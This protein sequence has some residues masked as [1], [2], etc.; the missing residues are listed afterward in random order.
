MNSSLRLIPASVAAVFSVLLATDLFAKP[1][2]ASFAELVQQSPVI[3][4]GR[5][6]TEGSS[7]P[8]PGSG[9][10]PFKALQVL[11]GDTSL[12]GRDIQ[13]CNSPPPMAEYPDLSK[14]TGEVVL[15]LSAEKAGC[16]E[17]SH[18]T[19]SVAGVCDGRVD[20]AAMAD[21]PMY[22]S[23]DVFLKKLRK[24]ISRQAGSH[25]ASAPMRA[26]TSLRDTS[27][28]RQLE[29]GLINGRP[30]ARRSAWKRYVC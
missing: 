24:L 30:N 17:Y 29:P 15:F 3:V 26:R 10:V 8:T 1:A 25:P 6:E 19:I 7:V 22:L 28:M 13:L 16:F 12:A 21:Q 23:W 18:T 9:W 11:R 4:F 5:L 2:G 20:T 14:L 27:Q